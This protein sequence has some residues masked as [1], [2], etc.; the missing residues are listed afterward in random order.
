M[1]R[2]SGPRLVGRESLGGCFLV[3][4]WRQEIIKEQPELERRAD[5]VVRCGLRPLV[6]VLTHCIALSAEKSSKDNDDED[7]DDPAFDWTE[8]AAEAASLL[9]FLVKEGMA[10]DRLIYE[11]SA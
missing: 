5:E 10:T 3:S 8:C 11:S 7:D 4:S 6:T 2:C 1:V 9:A